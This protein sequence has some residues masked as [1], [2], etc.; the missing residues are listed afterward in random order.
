MTRYVDDTTSRRLVHEPFESRALSSSDRDAIQTYS[1][2][3]KQAITYHQLNSEANKIARLIRATKP[4]H[5]NTIAICMDKGPTLIAVILAVLKLGCAWTPVDPRAPAKR[6]NA[7]LG[8]LGDC[9]LLV[10]PGYAAD[11]QQCPPPTSVFIWD[12]SS[13][14]AASVQSN[15]NIGRV[16]CSPESPCH[17][18]WTSGTTGVPKGVVIPH[19]SVVNNVSALVQ[20]F[21][22]GPDTRTLQFAHFTFDVFSLDVFMTLGVG[23]CLILGDTSEM[24]TDLTLFTKSAHA[25]YAHL[26]P[27]VIQ[28]LDPERIGSDGSLQVLASSGEAVTESIVRAWADRVQLFNCY[29]PTETDVVTAHRME[30]G[31]SPFCIGRE[32]AGCKVSIRDERGT[33]L[34]RGTPGEICVSGIQLM[35]GYLNVPA[36]THWHSQSPEGRVYRTGDLGKMD[37]HGKIFCFGRKDHEVKVRGNR[38]NLAEIEETVRLVPDVRSTAVV[39]PN[40]GSLQGQLC[41]FLQADLKQQ[42]LH[43][44]AMTIP[45]LELNVSDEAIHMTG[46]VLNE[47]QQSLSTPA[48]PTNWWFVRELPLTPSGKID[49]RALLQWVESSAESAIRL[50][51]HPVGS[52]SSPTGVDTDES[53]SEESEQEQAIRLIWS[54]ILGTDPGELSTNRPFYASGGH[55]LLAARLVAALRARGMDFTIQT[56]HDADTIR[57]QASLLTSL[58]KRPEPTSRCEAEVPYALIDPAVDLNTLK[59]AISKVCS[60]PQNVIDNIYP[61]TP[62]QSGL[63]AAS[64]QRPGMYICEMSLKARGRLDQSALDV[65]WSQL[66]ALEPIFRTRL[67]MTP[68]YGMFQVVL[69]P[70]YAVGSKEPY[71]RPMRIGSQLWQYTLEESGVNFRIHH[72]ILDGAQVLLMLDKLGTLYDKQIRSNG[73]LPPRAGI[74]VMPGPPFTH[75][76]HS[77]SQD[78]SSWTHSRTF[79]LRTMKDQSATDYPTVTSAAPEYSAHRTVGSTMQWDFREL[80]AKCNVPPGA[81]LGALWS[82][83]YSGF[84][85]AATVVY[86][87]VHSGRD[88]AVDGI[89]EMV[90][91]T[92]AITPF[93]AVADRN[94][95]FAQLAAAHQTTLCDMV[96]FRHFGLQHIQAL[97]PN[98]RAAC[99]FRALLKIDSEMDHR[100]ADG[101]LVLEAISEARY[102]YPLVVFLTMKADQAVAVEL[103]YEESFISTEE[104]QC[105]LS[106]LEDV[107]QQ[108]E[109]LGAQ[110]TL[111]SL[112]TPSPTCLGHIVAS[113][114]APATR[115]ICVQDIFCDAALQTPEAPAIFDQELDV[116][117]TYSE[118]ERLSSLL[119]SVITECGA[120]SGSIVALCMESGAYA[121][122]AILAAFQAGCAYVPI[123]P[124]HPA[125]RQ[126][127]FIQQVD[128]NIL[129]CLSRASANYAGFGGQIIKVDEIVPITPGQDENSPASASPGR[130]SGDWDM[131]E[132]PSHGK[133]G[134]PGATAFVLYTS[135]STGQP[136]GVELTHRNIATS[137]HALVDSFELEQGVRLFQFSALT[138]DMSLLEIFGAW[139]RRGCVCI[140]SK[141]SRMNRASQ[142]L[143]E[144]GI[145]TVMATPTVASLFQ[146]EDTLQLRTMVIGGERLTREIVD[147]WAAR[148]RLYQLYGPTEGGI[149]VTCTRVLPDCLEL[150]NL[151]PT[152]NARVWI[153][154]EDG[155][156]VPSGYPGEIAISGPT[157]AR[158]YW[159]DPERTEHA[160]VTLMPSGKKESE[161]RIYRTGDIG[162]RTQD[163]MIRFYGRKDHQVKARGIRIELGEIE[164]GILGAGSDV[165]RTVV[166]YISNKL[167]AFL[168]D[169]TVVTGDADD[170]EKVS[171]DQMAPNREARVS[172]I[173][174]HLKARLPEY[175]IPSKFVFTTPWPKAS[176]GKTDRKR[177]LAAYQAEDSG[178]SSPRKKTD[179][180]GLEVT[181]DDPSRRKESES[182]ARFRHTLHRVLDLPGDSKIDL[183]DTFFEM[184]GDSFAAMKFVAAAREENLEIS[185]RDIFHDPKLGSMYNLMFDKAPGA[186]EVAGRARASSSDIQTFSLKDFVDPQ[187]IENLTGF[188]I[189]CLEDVYPCT[190]FQ[191]G[192]A[193]LAS[194]PGDLYITRHV[195]KTT[196]CDQAR[197]TA[198]L[199]LVIKR[200]SI[201][202]TIIIFSNALGALQ[203]AVSP[204]SESPPPIGL[205]ASVQDLT[206]QPVQ[207]Q[208]QYLCNFHLV[209]QDG[210]VNAFGVTMSHAAYDGWSQELFLDDISMAYRE[211]DLAAPSATFGQYIAFQHRRW[212]DSRSR[213]FWSAYLSNAQASSWPHE[214]PSGQTSLCADRRYSDAAKIT[215]P[216]QIERRSAILRGAWALL[217][218]KYENTSDPCFAT[219]FSGRIGDFPHI[220]SVRGPTM[221]AAVVHTSIKKEEIVATFLKQQHDDFMAM[222]PHSAHGLQ[223]I[224]TVSEDAM[225]ACKVR[226]MLVVQFAEKPRSPSTRQIEF[227][228]VHESMLWGY[229]VTLECVPTQEGVKLGI[230]YDPAWISDKEVERLAGQYMHVVEQIATHMYDES[231]LNDIDMVPPRHLEQIQRWNDFEFAPRREHL[232]ER[233]QAVMREYPRSPAMEGPDGQVLSY[234]DLQLHVCAVAKV[235]RD[236]GVKSRDR[237]VIRMAKS[238]HQIVALLAIVRVG[239]TFVPI[240]VEWPHGR[241]GKIVEETAAAFAVVDAGKPLLHAQSSLKEI[242][243]DILPSA[244]LAQVGF[245]DA[246]NMVQRQPE[247]LAYIL[248]TSGSTGE[249][250]GILTS[251]M[252]ACTTIQAHQDHFNLT[253]ESRVFHFASLTFDPSITDI[254]GTLSVGG[255][256]CVPSERQRLFELENTIC[257]RR[258]NWL[259]LTPSVVGL[260]SPDNIPTVKTVLLAGEASPQSLTDTWVDRVHLINNYGPTEATIS[261][262]ACHNSK[263]PNCI[264]TAIGTTSPWIVDPHDHTR[265]APIGTVG[266]LLCVGPGLAD[267][268]LNNPQGTA[269]AFVEPPV[270]VNRQGRTWKAYRT[271][272]LVR[273]NADSS[274]RILGRA[275]RQLKIRGKRVELTEIDTAIKRT[276]L[277]V[278]VVTEVIRSHHIPRLVAFITT[279]SSDDND[280][281]VPPGDT[282]A[283]SRYRDSQAPSQVVKDIRS[284]IR[285]DLPVYMQP[286]A[287]ITVNK[288]PL[289][290]SGKVDRHILQSIAETWSPE[291]EEEEEEGT[292]K[293]IEASDAENMSP[294]EFSMQE[295]WSKVLG[296]EKRRVALHDT[297]ANL[298]GD[299]LNL[300]RLSSYSRSRGYLLDVKRIHLGLTLKQMAALLSG[301]GINRG[302]QDPPVVEPFSMLDDPLVASVRESIVRHLQIPA[303]DVADIYPLSPMQMALVAS[304]AKSP[305]SYTRKVTFQLASNVD[306]DQLEAAVRRV[307]QHQEILR[308]AFVANDEGIWA[309]AVL[310]HI[311]VMQRR[312]CPQTPAEVFDANDDVPTFHPPAAFYIDKKDSHVHLSAIIHHVAMDG[313]SLQMLANDLHCAYS[314]R[315]LPDRPSYSTF[316]QRLETSLSKD[317]SRNAWGA[318]LDRPL[319]TQVP[320]PEST[321]ET[322]ERPGQCVVQVRMP[323]LT[324]SE[325]SS[326]EILTAALAILLRQTSNAPSICFGLVLSGRMD[327]LAGIENIAGPTF[328]TVPMI[329]DV[330]PKVSMGDLIR[331]LRED[332]QTI[333][334]HEQFGL[335]N[336][337]KLN[338][339]AREAT[340]FTTLMVVQPKRESEGLGIFSQYTC[341]TLLPTS[342]YPL[343]IECNLSKGSAEIVVAY[344]GKV[345]GATEA[346]WLTN[347]FKR[348]VEKELCENDGLMKPWQDAILLTDQDEAQ[349]DAWNSTIV[350][351]DTRPLHTS[352]V[353]TAT[354]HPEAV[355]IVSHDTV[356]T[357]A[358]LDRLSSILAC[359]LVSRGVGRCDMV[360]LM[361][362]KSA[363]AVVAILAVLKAGAAYVP[364]DPLHPQARLQSIKNGSE[365]DIVLCSPHMQDTC[366]LWEKKVLL[367]HSLL[368]QLQSQDESHQLTSTSTTTN[369]TTST[370]RPENPAYVMF[371]SGSSGKPKGVVISHGAASTSIRDQIAAF[372]FAPGGRVM[373]FCSF[374]FDVSVMEIFATLSSGAT[375]FIPSEQDRT[376]HLAKY[377]HDNEV[378]TAI[379]TPTVVRNLLTPESVPRLRQLILSSAAQINDYGP[380]ETT[381]DS[382]T[383]TNITANTSPANVGKPIS[384]NLWIVRESD[385]RQLCPLGIAGELLISGPTLANGYLNDAERTSQ[386]FIDGSALPWTHRT[387]AKPRRLY[388]TGDLARYSR[389]GEIHILGRIDSQI[390]LRGLRIEAQEIERVLESFDASVRAGV[391]LTKSAFTTS[392]FAA[393]SKE[394]WR[395]QGPE[396][397]ILELTEETRS[398]VDE[399]PNHAATLLPTYMRPAAIVPLTHLP[400]TSS[401]KLDRLAL[402]RIAARR[403]EEESSTLQQQSQP[404]SNHGRT[405]VLSQAESDLRD[406]WAKVLGVDVSRIYP[407]SSFFS[408]GGESLLAMKLSSAYSTTNQK[409]SVKSIFQFPT[410]AAM[411]KAI[412]TVASGEAAAAPTAATRQRWLPKMRLS[413]TLID[414]IADACNLVAQEIE[415]VYP[416]SPLQE[417]LFAASLLSSGAYYARIAY[418]LAPDVDLARFRASWEAV[419]Q[420]N[421]ILRT[422]IV[423]DNEQATR[424]L[425]AIIRRQVQWRTV[426]TEEAASERPDV[427]LGGQ[428]TRWTLLKG[429]NGR[430]RQFVLIIHHAL[431]DDTTL[432]VLFSEFA[433]LYA[434]GYLETGPSLVGMKHYIGFLESLDEKDM[435]QEW[436]DLLDGPNKLHFPP[437]KSPDYKPFTDRSTRTLTAKAFGGASWRSDQTA[438]LRAAWMLT[439]A[440]HQ[441]A[442]SDGETVCFGTVLSGRTATGLGL[443][444]VLGPMILS[445]PVVDTVNKADSLPEFLGRIRD[446]YVRA[447]DCSSLGLKKIRSIGPDQASA[448][449]FN[450]LFIIQNEDDEE[451]FLQRERLQGISFFEQELHHPYGLVFECSSTAT[452]V[453]FSA[454][455]DSALL[456][457][458]AISRLLD[459]FGTAFERLT[460]FRCSSSAKVSDV[461]SRLSSDVE[462]NLVETWN[463]APAA[464]DRLLHQCFPAVAQRWPT[465]EAVFA[466]DRSLTYEKLDEESSSLAH[467]LIRLGVRAGSL[468][469]VSFE[470]SSYMIVALLAVLKAGGAYVPISPD[471]P[472][473]RQEYIIEQCSTKVMLASTYQAGILH[474]VLGLDKTLVCV[475]EHFFQCHPVIKTLRPPSG[476]IP[477]SSKSLAYVL[478]TSGSTGTP[479]GVAMSHGAIAISMTR[480]A[481]LFGHAL[482]G[483]VRSLQ[484][485]DY[486]FDVSVMD[487]FPALNYGGCVCVPSEADRRGKVSSFIRKSKAEIAML[488]P[489]IADMLDPVDVPTLRAVVVGGEPMTESVRNRWLNAANS[490]ERVLYNVYGPTEAS[491]NVA[492]SRMTPKSKVSVIGTA[493]LGSQLWIAE[494]DDSNNLTPLGCVGELIITGPCLANGYLHAPEQTAR[495]FTKAP[496]WL[497]TRFGSRAYRTGDLARFAADGE[498]EIVGRIDAQVK[499]HG[500]RIELGEIEEVACRVEHVKSAV[501]LVSKT[502]GRYQLSL[503]YE[504]AAQEHHSK[505][506]EAIHERLTGSLP[507]AFIPSLYIPSAITLT[508]TGKIDRKALARQLEG[509]SPEE[510]SGFA[511]NASISVKRPLERE[512]QKELRR[513]WIRVLQVREEDVWLDT[514]FFSI[515]GDS[516]AII[517]LVSLMQ[518]AG[519][520]VTYKDVY[521]RPILETMAGLMHTAREEHDTLVDPD[522]FEMLVAD[523]KD[524]DGLKSHLAN[525]LNVSVDHICDA[526]PCSAMQTSL[527]ATSL[528][529]P[530]AYWCTITS[531]LGHGIDTERLRSSW[532]TIIR[533]NAI[534]RTVIVNSEDFGHIQVV[535]DADL[536]KSMGVYGQDAQLFRQ[537]LSS[538]SLGTSRTGQ[539][540][541]KLTLHHAIYDLWV[542]EALLKQLGQLCNGGRVENRPPFSRFIRFQ[543]QANDSATFWKKAMQG[544][545]VVKFPNYR[546][547]QDPNEALM[548]LAEER[549][550]TL[551][552]IRTTSHSTATIIHCAYALVLSRYAFARDVCYATVQS[553]RNIP[554]R[555]ASD[556]VGPLM[557]VSFFR[558][559]CSHNRTV[560]EML[561]EASRFLLDASSHQHAA[562]TVVP[563]LFGQSIVEMGNMLVVQPRVRVP[564][565]RSNLFNRTSTEMAQPG[566]VLT[567]ATIED[568]GSVNLRIQYAPEAMEQGNARLFLSHLQQAI[569]Q[570]AQPGPSAKRILGDISLLTGEDEQIAMQS[571]GMAIPPPTQTVVDAMYRLAEKNPNAVAV[572]AHDG[573]LT[574]GELR[575]R[576]SRLAALLR[577]RLIPQADG[578]VRIAACSE[579]N[580][581]AVVIQAAIFTIRGAAFIPL[582]PTSA[583]E[584][585]FQILEDSEADIVLSSPFAM[586][587]VEQIARGREVLEISKRM[588]GELPADE[589]SNSADVKPRP[590]SVAYITYTS[591]STGRA[592]GCIIDHGPLATTI[593]RLTE[594]K[595]MGS[596]INTL[597]ASTW[598][599]DSHLSQIWEPLTTGG[600]ICV[601]SETEMHESSEATLMKYNVNHAFFTPTQAKMIDFGR[602]PCVR[603]IAMG[604]ECI[605]FNLTRLFEA[606]IRIFNEYGPSEATVCVTGHELTIGDQE[607]NKIGR[608]LSGNCWAVEPDRPCRLAPI[609][610]IGELVA[611]GTLARGYLNRPDLTREAFFDS[612]PWAQAVCP[613]LYRTG[614]LVCQNLDGS[615]RYLGRADTQ[616]KINGVRIEVA[617]VESR[618]V[619]IDPTVTAV[620][621]ALGSGDTEGSKTLVAFIGHGDSQNLSAQTMTGVFQE[622]W[623]SIRGKLARVLPRIMVPRVWIPLANVSR[624]STGKVDRKTL[625][626]VFEAYKRSSVE[627]ASSMNEVLTDAEKVM[628][629]LWAS[630]L[631]CD[632]SKLDKSSN[633]FDHGDS[634]TAIGLVAAASR[635]GYHM[636]VSSLFQNSSLS[637]MARL[638]KDRNSTDSFL[639]C[640]DPPAFSLLGFDS[641]NL[642]KED[643]GQSLPSHITIENI[644]PVTPLQEMA[645]VANQR[646]HRAYYAWFV[647]HLTGTLDQSRLQA[648]CNKLVQLH[649]LLRTVFFQSGTTLY[650]APLQ[651]VTPDYQ[652]I[653]WG[654]DKSCVPALLKRS[655]GEEGQPRCSPTRFRLLQHTPTHNLLAVGLSHAQYDGICLSNILDNLISIYN[656][657]V[658]SQPPSFS[659]L[660]QLLNSETQVAEAQAFWRKRLGGSRMTQLVGDLQTNRPLLDST[661]TKHIELPAL[662][663]RGSPFHAALCLAWAIT[664]GAATNV[665]DV[666]FGTLSSG[667]NASIKDISSLVGPCITTS[668][669][670]VQ[671]DGP[672]SFNSI[673]DA[674]TVGQALKQVH[675]DYIETI[676]YEHL[677]LRKI[678]KD[679]TDWP[680]TTRFSSMVQHQ[681]IQAWDPYPTNPASPPKPAADR[682]LQWRNRGSI[683]YRGTCDEVDLWVSS[684]PMGDNG[685][686]LSMLFS[687]E[688]LPREVVQILLSILSVN[689]VSVLQ[690]AHGNVAALLEESRRRLEGIRLPIEP[691]KESQGPTQHETVPFVPDALSRTSGLLQ[692]LWC[693]VLGSAPE[694]QFASSDSFYAQGG[695]SM[696]AATLAGLAQAKGLPLCV[697]DMA[698]CEGFGAQIRRIEHGRRGAPR[699]N[700]LEWDMTDRMWEN[701]G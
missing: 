152:V 348:I 250:K 658:V 113:T 630:V 140:P 482:E 159:K 420:R 684:V 8:E 11:F 451:D 560:D 156:P 398:W 322:V 22:L 510:L 34:P 438:V 589:G 437:R 304:S 213:E 624:T 177:L 55:S 647:L 187:E 673:E 75:F 273:Y 219:I 591:G 67:A 333:R 575:D 505:I 620:V 310:R 607:N 230:S 564:A 337:S 582:D 102:D 551:P 2:G 68:D 116:S 382:A 440:R 531:E 161:Q 500:I 667:R 283:V 186:A 261:T 3:S 300:M 416:C 701:D 644:Y 471:Y 468:V 584:R 65:A 154:D 265:L 504:A 96:P 573:T 613:R 220:E 698:E 194:S 427:A 20:H 474:D 566:L 637:E 496:T 490:P 39:F 473:K 547:V 501:A 335:R 311:W 508:R 106:R 399:I 211:G 80:A 339:C 404:S 229:P 576:A 444:E 70:E 469:P 590:D 133:T 272:D 274:I 353:E 48:V 13:S 285:Q 561:E 389:N 447:M 371:T 168:A 588:L 585:N 418:A 117:L 689:L 107:G 543:Q 530:E 598:S 378:Q 299:S 492:V 533:Q 636:F 86:G 417:N 512:K 663:T 173:L 128:A 76:L 453:S 59:E 693:Q 521:A 413:K 556:I 231:S 105:I 262:I 64:L 242:A 269:R 124:E 671:L 95:T 431:Y 381:I 466:H 436:K 654:G 131:V 430:A 376:S 319:P 100:M 403:G 83:V 138:F 40:T 236:N 284:S 370:A 66:V 509:Y 408:M 611:G 400:T 650:Q 31:T 351:L 604:G 84:A 497:P 313:A 256:I 411:A 53:G 369:T 605:N 527:I 402:G 660:V 412:E 178:N 572:K 539:V 641:L 536:W 129:L 409:L 621:A 270:W 115:D 109:N 104:V 603:S 442:V 172:N 642:A 306:L 669:V 192:V 344:D 146:V 136:K 355:A 498:I 276:G 85:D 635:S 428:L 511:I 535:L 185:V 545:S 237:V 264:G 119:A 35:T 5:L 681:N 266:E 49:R 215:W 287:I 628:R 163:G 544:A 9:H 461:L 541:F 682:G 203:L 424:Y 483:S 529:N 277:V 329:C 141:H 548:T 221:S 278:Q 558:S 12:E 257:Q 294:I 145:D 223:Y 377:I 292:R 656:G 1:A 407:D 225:N 308:T 123:N 523:P 69:A 406:Q 323:S 685:M 549:L 10:A 160:F 362:E 210:V 554:L 397:R 249:P 434:K 652:K 513:L 688:T 485:C 252:A 112:Q 645:I 62:M 391:V 32:T 601:P 135:G 609:G 502:R 375:L 657:K 331:R 108:L 638:I 691:S 134:R 359:Y 587:V 365:T 298:G 232:D 54:D 537:P 421:P 255:C 200:T 388:K 595:E 280:S 149:A 258:A 550:M 690:N 97:G 546:I 36:K 120:D 608:A 646:W 493:V 602:A 477:P 593:T 617:E 176:S 291:E 594:W 662:S 354:K 130:T 520:S 475:D 516:V 571:C 385:P 390:K 439:I 326:S 525:A 19:Q 495:A 137:V 661:V 488:T 193:A 309:Q 680:S 169:G 314:T 629:S 142:A 38:V 659:R 296:I 228:L 555:D 318:F 494:P 209:V 586:G 446:K 557:T 600:M 350:D 448:C 260:L 114:T 184:G 651:G 441:H 487:I 63:M 425:Q 479:K 368:L 201:L 98:Y 393:V 183:S 697:Q 631:K 522:P 101:P 452:G 664:L 356:Y 426:E 196:P 157:V 162:R 6:R 574:Y 30:I 668:P 670:R 27:S 147:R 182:L 290:T 470:K 456:D 235:L 361:L 45:S 47:L 61:C 94:M 625:Q 127:F 81:L 683:A 342:Q 410:L 676:P 570:L 293:A 245:D 166:A 295:L 199:A 653:S 281:D 316:I 419:Y 29:G 623:A 373:N 330:E 126:D 577:R 464:P 167:V 158:G 148:L 386:A 60:V 254:F 429:D 463:E 499:I 82:L 349:I 267:G 423:R 678:A 288:I 233:V 481:E 33:E 568:E 460:E 320:T 74:H 459:H 15:D 491:V 514:N 286:W 46:V 289:S 455:Y 626:Q 559:D 480:H 43:R 517:G 395:Q 57:K 171:F 454:S 366:Q 41:C 599:F 532:E 666:V 89:E 372:G 72:S 379:L 627:E 111:K 202:R 214:P 321:L 99:D 240:D 52:I 259:C 247:D 534:L 79:W 567:Q 347:H 26:T 122:V 518:R 506:R 515:G 519:Y 251:H 695:D 110:Q 243:V 302:A 37:S 433:Q 195:F 153:L 338:D 553:G 507:P 696:G 526:Y 367:D 343:E 165:G 383:N 542:Q 648:A 263:S 224:K 422:R 686:K 238:L 449:N 14:K 618:I 88:A 175:M 44:G 282:A 246:T 581:T 24:L 538:Y 360:P 665:S 275:D 206:T 327:N 42:V 51:T 23:G 189:D 465:R 25:S 445:V 198:A 528:R 222:L 7:I 103:S 77:L 352:F 579:R 301:G 432:R 405:M 191:E 639:I 578:E 633:F 616:V 649:P 374:T 462:A 227:D 692:A 73:T 358:E 640:Q 467:E 139:A 328:T 694:K 16:N 218:A 205:Y 21:R 392:L 253:S 552:P 226:T 336:I 190:P 248:F 415:D 679:C 632:E 118:V 305:G 472:R 563:Q 297:F 207:L 655:A 121:L 315:V 612:P 675:S 155:K 179:P 687:E 17:I 125:K 524:R 596:N 476:Y 346:G 56:L 132:T 672:W 394:E 312:P 212:K 91:P 244:P 540:V 150:H 486:T 341:E 592:K 643:L 610:T 28:L 58:E 569:T 268:Y 606:K 181:T 414:T 580:T 204:D 597:W 700:E 622:K 634:I 90:A 615:F 197:F 357:Y 170:E 363:I 144:M 699:T 457:E 78:S 583:V 180:G 93:I 380:T 325:W 279:A 241:I 478:Y 443:E 334:T 271:G 71:P 332:L 317:E 450:N 396:V 340:T 401:G 458:V 164:D 174:A 619:E 384:G 216:S 234:Q 565:S 303:D 18:L 4:P 484:F 188:S 387:T 307:V 239:A 50:R 435:I 503:F 674:L 345:V 562:H 489:T 217:L 324:E 92:I 151:G 87:M 208:E 364:L 614:D 143:R 677:G